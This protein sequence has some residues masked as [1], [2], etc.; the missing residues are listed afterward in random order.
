MPKIINDPIH[1][2]MTITPA[3]LA[4]IDTPQFQRLRDLKQLGTTYFIFPGASHNR[5]EHSIGVAHLAGRLC[6]LLRERQPELGIDDRDILLLEL[7]G[8]CHDLGHGPF[9]HAFEMIVRNLRPDLDFH[10]ETMSK[11]IFRFMVDENDLAAQLNL[12]EDDVESVLQLIHGVVN[13]EEKR[14]KPFLYDIVA[15]AR[16][17]I[18]VDR[19]DYLARDCANVGIKSTYDYERLFQMC[20]VIDGE[21]CF[22]VKEAYNVLQL[23]HTRYSLHK[24]IYTHKTSKSIEFMIMDIMRAADPVLRIST[25]VDD[26]RRYCKLTDGILFNIEHSEDESEGMVRA[27]ALVHR[28]RRRDLYRFIGE[29]MLEPEDAA[30]LAARPLTA[31]ALLEHHRASWLTIDPA[32]IIVDPYTLSYTKKDRNPLDYVHFYVHFDS[33]EKITVASHK[34]SHLIPSRFQEF[35]LR[36]FC[37]DSRPAITAALKEAFA[38]WCRHVKSVSPFPMYTAAATMTLDSDAEDDDFGS[39]RALKRQRTL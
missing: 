28:L 2:Y 20:K 14:E 38:L 25:A 6:R 5:F 36:I 37:K 9:S 22:Y 31:E 26:V 13:D 15:N 30:R 19:L 12:T 17:G 34:V 11:A 21:I 3:M 8:L 27:R 39:P 4:V 18:D 7:A 16:N 23:Y 1:G 29:T 35:G 10:H 32:D 33:T 24:Q